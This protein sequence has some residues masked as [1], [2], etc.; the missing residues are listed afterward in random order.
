MDKE[1][2][3]Y[4]L[5]VGTVLR[6][7]N[8]EYRIEQV[9]GVGGFGI[10]YKVSAT[11]V[12]QNVPIFTYFAV[13]EH[14]LKD[15]CERDTGAADV[16]CSRPSQARVEESR[17]D[18]LSEARRLNALSGQSD[19][20]VPVSE[21][22]EANNTV[23]YV[24][25]YLDGGSLRD[26]VKVGGV[27]PEQRALGIIEQVARAVA[28]LHEHRINHLDL[29]PDNIMFKTVAD[30]SKKPVIIDFGLAKH[31]DQNG[32]PTSTVR[33]QG[34][35]DGYAPVEQ[36]AGLN[37]FAPQADVYALGAMLYYMLVGRDPVIATE[38]TSAAVV[39]ALPKDVS[40]STRNA[41]VHAMQ[42]NR[43]DRTPS[44][45]AFLTDLDDIGTSSIA[46]PPSDGRATQ[47]LLPEK[48]S[49]KTLWI[50]LSA[51][52][53]ALV[54]AGIVLLIVFSGGNS[55]N[56]LRDG[57]YEYLD[58]LGD[59][60]VDSTVA[61]TAYYYGEDYVATDETA[62]AVADYD[63]DETYAADSA[64]TAW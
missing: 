42:Q 14:F 57:E 64:A 3:K 1:E 4:A 52:A 54:A 11:L 24:M 13:K 40:W 28:F 6:S 19:N 63:Y 10:T 60:S 20:I 18:F 58:E 51:V 27:L 21:V 35:S 56:G 8:R 30:G 31:Y 15:A 38:Q 12:Y 62:A 29:K 53:A 48:K 41:I 45:G 32:R 59:L 2:F 5:P 55:G 43:A 22:F 44:V 34:C 47:I 46:L 25:E 33:V 61:D 23:Y 49:R 39:E 50:V 16:V 9:L 7:P 17:K 37:A 26:L 36:Y